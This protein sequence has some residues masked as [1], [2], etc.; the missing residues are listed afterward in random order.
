MDPSIVAAAVAAASAVGAGAAAGLTETAQKAVADAYQ[1]LKTVLSR[2]HASVDV[3]VVEARPQLE[4]RRAV[5]VEELI[6]AGAQNDPEYVTAAR[7]LVRVLRAVSPAAVEVVG[8]KLAWFTAAELDISGVTATGPGTSG[9]IAEHVEVGG[10]V[11]VTDIV[12]AQ[13][14]PHPR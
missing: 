4:S 1:A 6:A 5:L 10:K 12:A 11:T 7:E 8:V 3:E 13:E 2:N 9:F 14:P